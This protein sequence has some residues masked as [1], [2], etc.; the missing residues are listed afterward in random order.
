LTGIIFFSTYQSVKNFIAK[1]EWTDFCA[2]G[3]FADC[4]LIILMKRSR[5][6]MPWHQKVPGFDINIFLKRLVIKKAQKG[7][8]NVNV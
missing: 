8:R 6:K 1:L 7:G 4:L 2:R 5:C 3:F